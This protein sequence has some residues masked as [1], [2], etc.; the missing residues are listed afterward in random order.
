MMEDDMEYSE[1]AIEQLKGR[2][3]EKAMK[4]ST[5]K[6][7][8]GDMMEALEVIIQLQREEREWK[9]KLLGPSNC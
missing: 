1:F 5:P 6:K 4:T 7:Y 9:K 2:L 8:A 3:A